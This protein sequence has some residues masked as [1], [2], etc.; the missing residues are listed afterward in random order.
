MHMPHFNEVS[1]NCGS[2]SVEMPVDVKSS[3]EQVFDAEHAQLGLQPHF[4]QCVR[5]ATSSGTTL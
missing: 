2:H 4:T 1:C 5:R 3:G